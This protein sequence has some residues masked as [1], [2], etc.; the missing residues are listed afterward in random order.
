MCVWKQRCK[1]GSSH[2]RDIMLKVMLHNEMRVVKEWVKLFCKVRVF[3]VATTSDCYKC[4][5]TS[6]LVAIYSCTSSH[7][8]VPHFENMFNE[9]WKQVRNWFN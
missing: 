2:K 4:E 7:Y 3:S 8:L 1:D 5:L 6:V 9:L